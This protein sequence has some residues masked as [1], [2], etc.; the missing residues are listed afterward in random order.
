MQISAKMIIFFIINQWEY[1]IDFV[2]V[3]QFKT[4]AVYT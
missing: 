1:F 2:K 4:S 3:A